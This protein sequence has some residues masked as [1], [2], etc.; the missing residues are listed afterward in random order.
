[1]VTQ[2]RRCTRASKRGRKK[3]ENE[4]NGNENGTEKRIKTE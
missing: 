1:M 4:L 3:N 2:S